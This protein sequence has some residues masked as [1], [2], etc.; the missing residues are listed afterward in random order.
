MGRGLKNENV[1]LLKEA[2]YP[3]DFSFFIAILAALPIIP[4]IIA[5]SKRKPG[6]SDFIKTLWRNGVNFLIAT[7]VLNII[8]I[9]VPLAVKP[10]YH[11]NMLGWIQLAIAVGIIIFLSTS[12]RV[13]DTFAD[14]PEESDEKDQEK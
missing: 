7:A 2:I 3:D 9:F 4:V 8:I 13:K 14:F 11:I 6:A 1:K 12:Q 10:Y 5:Y